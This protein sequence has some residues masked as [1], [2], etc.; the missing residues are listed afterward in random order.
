MDGNTATGHGEQSAVSSVPSLPLKS[1]H[2]MQKIAE[3]VDAALS[4]AL[5]TQFLHETTAECVT[6]YD[7]IAY[8]ALQMASIDYRER[9]NIQFFSSLINE[10]H[11]KNPTLLQHVSTFR[12]MQRIKPPLMND[13][14][15][16]HPTLI[17]NA[18]HSYE[19]LV[20]LLFNTTHGLPDDTDPTSLQQEYAYLWEGNALLLL[21]IASHGS[22]YDVLHS[23][24]H[25]FKKDTVNIQRGEEKTTIQLQ[26][27]IA[28]Q[29]A[30]KIHLLYTLHETIA[31]HYDNTDYAQSPWDW[32]SVVL[33]QDI[34]R[35]V[36]N[37]DTLPALFEHVFEEVRQVDLLETWGTF[38]DTHKHGA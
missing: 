3:T 37:V 16:E 19:T 10:K 1:F 23:F 28:A 21:W 20:A 7:Y 30:L 2:S 15:V 38:H 26:C 5:V 32:H 33:M 11:Q 36:Q 6:T 25:V 8:E 29:R 35:N 18:Y 31:Q 4:T 22:V 9:S 13:A 17:F 34:L 24:E 12:L 27:M 14:T